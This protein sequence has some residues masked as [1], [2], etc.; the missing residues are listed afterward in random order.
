MLFILWLREITPYVIWMPAMLLLAGG[1]AVMNIYPRLYQTLA[2][3]DC[4]GAAALLENNR[5]QY[6]ANAELLYLLDGAMINLQCGD[7]AAAEERLHAAED[8]A[9]TLWTESISRNVAAMVTSDYSLKYR[10]EDY[11]RVMIHVVSA[12]GYLRMGQLDEA[13]VEVRRLDSLLNMYVAEYK[14]DQ[15]Y[16][17]DAFARYLSGIIHE[18]DSSYEDAFIDYYQAAE[19]YQNQKEVYGIDLP[20]ILAT[21]VLRTASMVGRSAD[22]R[23][24]ISEQALASDPKIGSNADSG[25]V[26]LIV[27]AGEGPR[28]IQDTA[29]VP[30]ARGPISIAFPRVVPGAALCGTGHLQLMGTNGQ[31]E[32]Q[33]ALVSDINSIAVKSLEGKKSRIIAKTIARAAAKQMVIQGIASTRKNREQQQAASVFLNVLNL[34]A[35]E[36]A[37]IRVW[38]TLPGQI[39]IARV[40]V[41][42]GT[43]TSRLTWCRHQTFDLGVVT[44]AKAKTRFLFLDTRYGNPGPFVEK[45]AS[46]TPDWLMQDKSYSSEDKI[47]ILKFSMVDQSGKSD[48]NCYYSNPYQGSYPHD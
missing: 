7:D 10:G 34:L 25:K 19:A 35:V 17:I 18:A 38:R 15:F 13:L 41:A 2:Q 21:D 22:V 39:L 28:K 24:L 11:E 43:Y 45:K 6:G 37:D 12:I 26:V 9:Q 40:F 36:K 44:V 14:D 31:V 4:S 30:T 29:V 5:R 16:K 1:C 8:L 46:L 27:F 23:R 32:G 48:G 3:G 33:L 20:E 47:P 42:P